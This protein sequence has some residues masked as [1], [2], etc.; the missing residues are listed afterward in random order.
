MGSGRNLVGKKWLILSF[1]LFTDQ[2]FLRD[3]FSIAKV[4]IY[5]GELINYIYNISEI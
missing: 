1:Y 5:E 3:F 4:Y 2:K